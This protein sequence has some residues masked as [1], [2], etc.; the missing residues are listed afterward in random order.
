M[1][2]NSYVDIVIHIF[3]LESSTLVSY[4]Y[5][6]MRRILYLIFV[7]PHFKFTLILVKQ[8]VITNGPLYGILYFYAVWLL[9]MTLSP[10]L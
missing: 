9:R 7:T 3:E 10:N 8:C 5:G 1:T 4:L 2:S 6:L